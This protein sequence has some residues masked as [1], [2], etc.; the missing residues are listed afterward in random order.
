MKCACGNAVGLPRVSPFPLSYIPHGKKEPVVLVYN[1]GMSTDG[2]CWF[3]AF[4]DTGWKNA[5]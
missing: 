1:G 3:C 5:A 2:K 4:P